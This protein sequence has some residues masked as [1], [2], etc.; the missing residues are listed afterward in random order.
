[1]VEDGGVVARSEARSV[2]AP[3]CGDG[4]LRGKEECD[5]GNRDNND[6][7]SADCRLEEAVGK[8]VWDGRKGSWFF[9]E[10]NVTV[11]GPS[12]Q[13]VTPSEARLVLLRQVL[14]E[15]AELPRREVVIVGAWLARQVDGVL[16]C[17]GFCVFHVLYTTARLQ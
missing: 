13:D 9:V 4:F 11:S 3:V 15:F 1:M 17:L 16:L 5:D 12:L 7:C 6:G 10:G 14:A 2:C 8:L